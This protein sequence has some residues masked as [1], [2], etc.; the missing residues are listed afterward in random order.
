MT[1]PQLSQRLWHV[2]E[3]AEFL[4][5][6]QS[7]VRNLVLR[8]QIPFRHVAGRLVFFPDEIDRWIRKAPGVS[9]EDLEK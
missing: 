5:R 7:A 3:C 8:R 2:Q 6:S 1:E 9:L 4:G